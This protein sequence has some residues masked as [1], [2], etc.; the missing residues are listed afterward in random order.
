MWVFYN[1]EMIST[2]ITDVVERR[3]NIGLDFQEVGDLLHL[4]W[5]IRHSK[6][7]RRTRIKSI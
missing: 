2:T 6:K 3:V 7:T 1:G 4:Y 5:L